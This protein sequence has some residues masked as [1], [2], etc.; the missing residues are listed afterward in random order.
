MVSQ[1]LPTILLRP[2]LSAG[3]SLPFRSVGIRYDGNQTR[4]T[5][6]GCGGII[7]HRRTDC[8]ILSDILEELGFRRAVLEEPELAVLDVSQP[9]ALGR[10]RIEMYVQTNLTTLIDLLLAYEEM[11]PQNRS[12]ALRYEA[13]IRNLVGAPGIRA[14]LVTACGFPTSDL[15]VFET[16]RGRLV[17]S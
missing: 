2:F 10:S 17:I 6:R 4:I 11:D 15:R 3:E 5:I 13:A 8:V 7:R 16:E 9:T 14:D 1:Q 12:L